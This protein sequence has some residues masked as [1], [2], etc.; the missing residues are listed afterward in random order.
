MGKTGLCTALAAI[1]VSVSVGQQPAVAARN[2]HN[3]QVSPTNAWDSRPFVVKSEEEVAELNTTPAGG[4]SFQPGTGPGR[5]LSQTQQYT[6]VRD[7]GFGQSP[8]GPEPAHTGKHVFSG[9]LRRGL[10]G[11]GRSTRGVP[12]RLAQRS[13]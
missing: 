4:A 11:S 10:C 3:N 12:A 7:G 13:L 1:C 9:H 6:V 5:S 2:V 8:P